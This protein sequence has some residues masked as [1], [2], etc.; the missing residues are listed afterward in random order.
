MLGKI[1]RQIAEELQRLTPSPGTEGDTDAIKQVL[2][3]LLRSMDLVTRE[4]F[5]AQTAVLMRTRAKVDRLTEALTALEQCI[6]AKPITDEN[7]SD[8]NPKTE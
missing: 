7:V 3:R 6:S 2:Q 5:D 4:E 8:A 1:S